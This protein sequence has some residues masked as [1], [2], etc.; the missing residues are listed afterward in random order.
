M[1][2]AHGHKPTRKLRDRALQVSRVENGSQQC[3]YDAEIPL[4]L[5]DINETP[6]ECTYTAPTI[7]DSQIPALLG[8]NSLI[9]VGAILDMRNMH[10][11]F[12]GPGPLNYTAHLPEGTRTF[13]LERA[14][15]GH[16]LLPCCKYM[17]QFCH[18]Q[19]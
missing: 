3:H 14:P 2:K 15:S 7:N 18:F 10:L 12:T 17:T 5:R 6:V 9:N 11:H 19:T 8:L 16:L 1:A 13:Q 4:T